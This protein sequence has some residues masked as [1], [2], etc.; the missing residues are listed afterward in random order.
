[1]FDALLYV[2]VRHLLVL[3]NL[4]R[5]EQLAHVALLAPHAPHVMC[6]DLMFCT[7]QSLFFFSRIIV[8]LY[9]LVFVQFYCSTTAVIPSE[10]SI[11]SL[12]IIRVIVIW[13]ASSTEN[14]K[15]KGWHLELYDFNQVRQVTEEKKMFRT[16]HDV[17]KMTANETRKWVLSESLWCF[18]SLGAL[19]IEG[20][21]PRAA[22]AGQ[23]PC[24]VQTLVLVDD[25]QQTEW[26]N[27]AKQQH[28]WTRGRRHSKRQQWDNRPTAKVCHCVQ[29][30][31]RMFQVVYRYLR[32]SKDVSGYFRMFQV[33]SDFFRLSKDV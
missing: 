6:S 21:V 7:I 28:E 31:L 3:T 25:S 9:W 10:G 27:D 2:F 4:R 32:M 16:A 8:S 11:K 15:P 26:W 5:H 29:R 1:M 24:G 23:I 19:V 22:A 12:L 17:W 13:D 33:I 30:C 14:T 18:D 20:C